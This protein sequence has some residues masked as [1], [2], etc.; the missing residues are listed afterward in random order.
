M[1]ES[2]FIQFI[3][4]GFAI[5]AFILIVKAGAA[6]LPDAGFIG[7]VRRVLLTV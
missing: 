2:P 1:S 6:C 5:I 7:S 3:V 4:F